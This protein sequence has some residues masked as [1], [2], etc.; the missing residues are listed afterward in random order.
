M[1]LM[2]SLILETAR[3]CSVSARSTLGSRWPKSWLISRRT[4]SKLMKYTAF[5][6]YFYVE[7]GGGVLQHGAAAEHVAAAQ[8]EEDLVR[9]VGILQ[10]LFEGRDLLP[11]REYPELV[12]HLLHE[13]VVGEVLVLV[14]DARRLDFEVLGVLE[15]VQPGEDELREARGLSVVLEVRVLVELAVQDRARLLDE[16][17]QHLAVLQRE[18]LNN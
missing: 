1:S 6:Y 4:S 10:E 7:V 8:V 14:E 5:H 12:G 15:G 16:L 18:V 3:S 13:L 17:Q 11:L 2:E 9:A